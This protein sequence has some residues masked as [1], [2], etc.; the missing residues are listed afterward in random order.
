M[1]DSPNYFD[2]EYN[3][4]K[5]KKIMF[6][7]KEKIKQGKRIKKYKLRSTKLDVFV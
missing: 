5:F 6:L 3:K 2:V 4:N 1:A 7:L